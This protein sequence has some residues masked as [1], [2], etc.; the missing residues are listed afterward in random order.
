MSGFQTT[1]NNQ[2]APAKA[3]DFASANPRAVMLAGPGELTAGANGVTVGRF[4]WVDE[5]TGVVTNNGTGVP[6]G[7]VANEL[8]ASITTWLNSNSSVIPAGMPVSLYKQGDF[9]VSPTTQALPGQKVFANYTTGAISTG[10]A[11]S[12]P[13]GASVT[14]SIAPAATTSVTGSIAPSNT[15]D[16]RYGVTTLN[17]T[18]V[19]SGT[20]VVGATISGTG[21]VSGTTIVSQL[22][23]TTGGTG[24]YEVS[25]PQTVASTTITA[26]YGVMTVTAVGSGALA[27]GDVL[28]GT[29]VTAGTYITSL[30]TGTGGN[31]TYNV[32]V[33]QTATSTTVTATSAVETSF[34]VQSFCAANELCKISSWS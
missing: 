26:A 11:G 25:I 3:G 7:F 34:Y 13:Q 12:P 16:G 17:V 14:A 1:I 20:L 10:T 22:T 21:V 15:P 31:G 8:Q 30:G 4:A 24:T 18:A 9:W 5:S 6:N 29:G 33:S 19:G 32:S 2:P 27:V 23:G 28:S